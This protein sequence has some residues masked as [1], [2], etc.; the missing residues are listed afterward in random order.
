MSDL[1][2]KAE[3]EELKSLSKEV[4][5]VSSKYQ[6]FLKGRYEV[7]TKEVEEEVPGENGAEPTKR[8]VRVPV[9]EPNGAK[10]MF[11]K[12]YSIEE[13]LNLLRGFKVQKDAFMEQQKAAQAEA[14]KKQAEAE[15]QNKV[16]QELAG[17][18]R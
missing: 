9:L 18:S 15:L 14:A 2:T 6:V 5:G 3:R 10:R 7:V 12:R 16:Q 8:T 4:F 1:A 11:L 13:T 17:S